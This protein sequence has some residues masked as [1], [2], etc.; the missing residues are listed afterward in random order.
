METIH[1]VVVDNRPFA[2]LDPDIS[3][4]L[5]ALIPAENSL[6]GKTFYKTWESLNVNQ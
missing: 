4:P 2:G 5:L 3:L 6:T 1:T